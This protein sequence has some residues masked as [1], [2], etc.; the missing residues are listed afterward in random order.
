MLL[1][2]NSISKFESFFIDYSLDSSL[3]N[4]LLEIYR[5]NHHQ[6]IASN[7]LDFMKV[8]NCLPDTV[9]PCI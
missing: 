7:F 3:C 1:D 9:S 6:F 8:K 5:V 2:K 4:I